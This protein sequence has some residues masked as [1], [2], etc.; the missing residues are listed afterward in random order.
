M[1]EPRNLDVLLGGASLKDMHQASR[2]AAVGYWPAPHA[3]GRGVATHA[4][5]L[6][7]EWPFADL[8]VA[9]WS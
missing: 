7:A 6:L 8:D 2:Q 9:R 5:R 4:V 1:I 3:R